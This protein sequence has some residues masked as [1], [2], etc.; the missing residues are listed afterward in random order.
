MPPLCSAAVSRLPGP[1][2]PFLTQ[3]G[4]LQPLEIL[5]P[6]LSLPSGT[7]SPCAAVCL[8]AGILPPSP[9]SPTPSSPS[10][11]GW[12]RDTYDSKQQLLLLLL[13]LSRFSRVRLCATP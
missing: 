11:L 10:M 13:L 1:A 8:R 7:W 4:P 6:Q 3:A 5:G 9:R 12:I 2:D